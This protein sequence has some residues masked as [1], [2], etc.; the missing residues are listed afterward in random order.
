MKKFSQKL[1][2][3]FAIQLIPIHAQQIGQ[4]KVAR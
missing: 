3:T 1:S 2:Q 4:L